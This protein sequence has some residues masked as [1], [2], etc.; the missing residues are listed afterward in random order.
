MIPNPLLLLSFWNWQRKT[1]Y[2][3]VFMGTQRIKKIIF[4][5]SGRGKYSKEDPINEKWGV[6]NYYLSVSL[7]RA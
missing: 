2:V 1:N 5:S 4:N 6:F 3:Q 7:Q